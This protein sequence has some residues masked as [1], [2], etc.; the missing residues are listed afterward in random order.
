MATVN[1]QSLRTSGVVVA[2]A[3]LTRARRSRAIFRCPRARRRFNYF[4]YVQIN[5]LVP[6]PHVRAPLY[7]PSGSFFTLREPSIN[8]S[9]AEDRLRK[10]AS[11]RCAPL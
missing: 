8:E 11:A 5:A 7:H 9:D 2:R 10:L 3:R 4:K 6:A 1:F